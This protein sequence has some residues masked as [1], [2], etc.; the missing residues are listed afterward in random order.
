MWALLVQPLSKIW[1]K[2]LLL[3]LPWLR[4]FVFKFFVKRAG[5][6][7]LK[8]APLSF[9][10]PNLIVTFISVCVINGIN[11]LIT[12]WLSDGLVLSLIS[13]GSV[14]AVTAFFLLRGFFCPH[15]KRERVV[16]LILLLVI[17]SLFVLF[18]VL[19]GN[20]WLALVLK[21]ALEVIFCFAVM[22]SELRRLNRAQGKAVNV[23][24]KSLRIS[25]EKF[26]GKTITRFFAPKI[27]VVENES[28]GSDAETTNP[29][30]ETT[31]PEM[32]I[33]CQECQEAVDQGDSSLATDNNR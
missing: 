21:L 20:S 23:V 18:R 22:L 9:H 29:D 11:F 28:T 10:A 1:S 33:K 7:A 26:I 32:S 16:L 2:L 8:K 6:T 12:L 13:T 31:N 19:V 30:D 27:N 14:T 17:F 25:P 5:R 15:T 24:M 4:G 3:F